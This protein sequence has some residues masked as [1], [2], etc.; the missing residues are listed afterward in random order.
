MQNSIEMFG[1]PI[2][3]PLKTQGTSAKQVI[4][5]VALIGVA[6]I[7]VVASIKAAERN[8]LAQMRAH[9]ENKKPVLPV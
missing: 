8:I 6:T 2:R 3:T 9:E 4:V 7:I 5:T 1:A